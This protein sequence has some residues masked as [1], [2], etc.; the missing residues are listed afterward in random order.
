MGALLIGL[1]HR[2]VQS[3]IEWPDPAWVLIVAGF[4]ALWAGGEVL[5]RRTRRAAEDLVDEVAR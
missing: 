3:I 4:V 2:H 5:L 1:L